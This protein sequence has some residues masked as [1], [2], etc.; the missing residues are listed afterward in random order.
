ML[1]DTTFWDSE[2]KHVTQPLVSVAV[3][4]NHNPSSHHQKKF[5]NDI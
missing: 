3:L 5:H 1:N 2:N 4:L